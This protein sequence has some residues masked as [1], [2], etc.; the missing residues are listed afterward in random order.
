MILP[1]YD[2]AR[3]SKNAKPEGQKSPGQLIVRIS[4][5]FDKWMEISEVGK[6][7]EDKEEL[8]GARTIHQIVF[9]RC[10]V[11]FFE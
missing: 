8:F 6:M 5:Y 4:N 7:F 9:E 1:G 2:I 3:S 10:V 11:K